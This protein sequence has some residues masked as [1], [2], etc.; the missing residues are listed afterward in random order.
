MGAV[1]HRTHKQQAWWLLWL[2]G[3]SVKAVHHHTIITAVYILTLTNI[4]KS[5]SV[6]QPPNLI[7]VYHIILVFYKYL[8]GS[9]K[10]MRN[11]DGKHSHGD[12][13]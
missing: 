4:T 8:Q 11:K 2:R 9:V 6:G 7:I 1:G 12:T 3:P 10:I 13:K 5:N